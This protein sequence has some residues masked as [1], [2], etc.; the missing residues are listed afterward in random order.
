MAGLSIFN[1]QVFAVTDV[2]IDGAVEVVTGHA[3]AALVNQA[4]VEW[5]ALVVLALARAVLSETTSLIRY[6]S[7]SKNAATPCKAVLMS[8]LTLH[9]LSFGVL[10][11]G[12]RRGAF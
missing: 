10:G 11:I 3:A 12:V 4:M 1:G 2:E 5:A 9:L 6:H 8:M 7:S